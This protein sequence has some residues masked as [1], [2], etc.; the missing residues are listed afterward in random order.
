MAGISK[1]VSDAWVSGDERVMK[2]AT[3]TIT[4]LPAVIHPNDTTA[5][6]GL[7]GNMSQSGTPTP[8]TP[9][10]PQECGERTGNLCPKGNWVQGQYREGVWEVIDTRMTSDYIPVSQ[11]QYTMSINNGQELSFININI[12]DSSKTWIGNRATIG[13][14]PFP[15]TSQ[16][17][18]TPVLLSNA[19]FIRLTV[20]AYNEEGYPTQEKIN[21]SNIMLNEGSTA[22]PYEP[23]GYKIPISSANTTTPVYLG[24]VQTVRQIKKLVLTGEE[25]WKKYGFFYIENEPYLPAAASG[26]NGKCS[27]YVYNGSGARLTCFVSG[28]MLRIYDQNYT[29][30]AE[31]K[32]FLAAQYAAGTPVTVWYVLATETTGIVNEPIR[33]IGDYADTVSG[34][35]IPTIAGADTLSV[36][37]TLQPSEVT[38]TYHGWHEGTVKDYENGDWQPQ[39]QALS[40]SNAPMLS[41]SLM[42]FPDMSEPEIEPETDIPIPEPEIE[43]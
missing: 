2:T 35:T 4:T 22:L 24:E 15:A 9:I 10:T 41:N 11:M 29:S 19:A 7:K 8:S 1:R 34:I 43:E 3:D 33:K 6:V 37:T 39:A 13:M 5:I 38:A 31:F 12:F 20:R 28:S 14:S 17:E 21:D 26:Y 25:N 18:T 36:D 30:S 27:H 16:L 23:Y 40:L 42:A 32:Q